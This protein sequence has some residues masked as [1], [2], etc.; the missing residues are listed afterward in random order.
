MILRF[1]SQWQNSSFQVEMWILKN[2]YLLIWVW[3][4]PNAWALFW[5]DDGDINSVVI[6]FSWVFVCLFVLFSQLCQ[7][8]SI[9]DFP[10]WLEVSLLLALRKHSCCVHPM[11][12]RVTWQERE[13]ASSCQQSAKK[14]K[15][16]GLQYNSFKELNSASK[17]GAWEKTLSPRWEHSPDQ[18]LGLAW[19]EMESRT[20]IIHTLTLDCEIRNSCCFKILNLQW[21]LA[22]H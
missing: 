12:G 15:K 16:M 18:H 11:Y 13:A 6:F 17:Q 3:L 21:F 2:L 4:L 8:F 9:Q 20:Q 14:K 10:K 1:C 22:Q 7:L 5:W 19:G